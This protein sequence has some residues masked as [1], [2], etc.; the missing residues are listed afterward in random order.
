MTSS[1]IS[2][3]LPKLERSEHWRIWFKELEKYASSLDVSKYITEDVEDFLE[4]PIRPKPSQARFVSI[5]KRQNNYTSSPT[6]ID[7][8]DRWSIADDNPAPT[9]HVRT[10]TLFAIR[11]SETL[12]PLVEDVS[13][14]KAW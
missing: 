14:P 9:A 13:D 10:T 7:G 8:T 11:E 2:V 12:R 1:T 3:S 4:E 5:Q 6:I